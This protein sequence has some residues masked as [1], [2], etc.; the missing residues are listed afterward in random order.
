[1]YKYNM[2]TYYMQ[3]YLIKNAQ[4]SDIALII[5]LCLQEN[6]DSTSYIWINTQLVC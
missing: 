3:I 1:M 5:R 2:L 6:I 4:R